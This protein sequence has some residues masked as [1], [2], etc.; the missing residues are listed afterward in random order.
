MAAERD[1]QGASQSTRFSEG[2]LGPTTLP[3]SLRMADGRLI[4]ATEE[5]SGPDYERRVRVSTSAPNSEPHWAQLDVPPGPTSTHRLRRGVAATLNDG[6]IVHLRRNGPRLSS[7]QRTVTVTGHGIDWEC[8]GRLFGTQVLDRSSG[9]WLCRSWL[10]RHEI[11]NSLGD[12]E[13][14]LLVALLI[15]HVPQSLSLF[16]SNWLP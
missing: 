11:R 3:G 15:H 5:I 10:T 4:T 1:I 6:G 13:T 8:R 7:I 14:A 12:A 16:F 2:D 9:D